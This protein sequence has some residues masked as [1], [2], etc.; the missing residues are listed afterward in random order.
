VSLILAESVVLLMGQGAGGRS[1]SPRAERSAHNRTWP[2]GFYTVADDRAAAMLEAR[3][4]SMNDTF[5][6]V[7]GNGGI[8]AECEVCGNDYDKRSSS[9]PRT[10]QNTRC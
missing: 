7:E 6:D 3:R 8:V 5:E 2:L 1:G 9:E 10:A 4:Q